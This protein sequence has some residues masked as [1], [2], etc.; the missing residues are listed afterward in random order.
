MQ[1]LMNGAFGA[2]L[3]VK[4]TGILLPLVRSTNNES[5]NALLKVT[6]LA[7]EKLV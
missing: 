6:I 2:F 4:R 7:K 3:P 5:H 1:A